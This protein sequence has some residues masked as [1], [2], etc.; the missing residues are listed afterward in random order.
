[1]ADEVGTADTP[2]WS[3]ESGDT[4]DVTDELGGLDSAPDP[5]GESG[6]S[7]PTPEDRAARQRILDTRPIAA[8]LRLA[9]KNRTLSAITADTHALNLR[10]LGDYERRVLYEEIS[11]RLCD[12]QTRDRICL[13]M[14]I[15]N[16]TLRRIL[17]DEGF[18]LVFD[19]TRQRLTGPIE[20]ALRDEHLGLTER[21]DAAA[22]R[23]LTRLAALLDSA[24]EE[25][26]RKAAS[27]LLNRHPATAPVRRVVG[28][29]VDS[30]RFD[31]DAARAMA[32][33]LGAVTATGRVRLAAPPTTIRTL[34]PAPEDDGPPVPPEA[35]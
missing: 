24:D 32:D 23:S 25:T 21:L 31:P 35:A 18:Q 13:D 11:L 30:I 27:D 7:P 17:R 4:Q 2:G 28:A 15:S 6:D 9:S 1:M 22:S 19:E 5:S 33:M 34:L 20:D 16:A 26:R 8:K 3:G 29:M 14:A 10:T 12:R